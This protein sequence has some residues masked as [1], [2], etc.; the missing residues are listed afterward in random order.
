MIIWS[1]VLLHR[2]LSN[3]NPLTTGNWQQGTQRFNGLCKFMYISLTGTVIRNG[4]R[5]LC[6]DLRVVHLPVPAVCRAPGAQ[7]L[8]AVGGPATT[9]RASLLA[10]GGVP[11]R[12]RHGPRARLAAPA[13]QRGQHGGQQ[14]H[15][16]RPAAGRAVAQVALAVAG[17][18]VLRTLVLV[19]VSAAA[20]H[21]VVPVDRQAGL[22]VVVR[23]GCRELVGLLELGAGFGVA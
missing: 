19:D 7:S 17:P 1:I 14:Q 4:H 22:V 21:A 6:G 2:Q 8:G 18:A 23:A 10:V 16:R 20:N 11:E 5:T 12:C 15:G 3:I 9:A 13:G